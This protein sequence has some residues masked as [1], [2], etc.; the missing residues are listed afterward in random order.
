M[1]LPPTFQGAPTSLLFQWINCL[2]CPQ[3]LKSNHVT[4]LLKTLLDPLPHTELKPKPPR[5]PTRSYQLSALPP[6]LPLR[7]FIPPSCCHP[8]RGHA[9]L[10]LPLGPLHVLSPLLAWHSPKRPEGSGPCWLQVCSNIFPGRPLLIIPYKIPYL[11]PLCIHP[12][13][14]CSAFFQSC[15]QH[16]TYFISVYCLPTPECKLY[17]GTDSLDLLTVLPPGHGIGPDTLME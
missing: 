14:F 4:S 7:P 6:L 2:C 11:Y 15:Y 1:F 9:S 8:G 3:K 10:L 5:R 16:V 17:D 13:P 12:A